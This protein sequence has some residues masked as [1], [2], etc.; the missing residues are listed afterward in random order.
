MSSLGDVIH[1]LPAVTELISAYPDAAIDWVVEEAFEDIPRLHPGLREVIPVAIR[2]WRKNWFTHISEVLAFKRRL[3]LENYDVIIDA[4]G[5]L[6]SALVASL[7]RGKRYGLDQTSSREPI[8]SRFYDHGIEVARDLH[9]VQRTRFLFAQA[10]Q[11]QVDGTANYGL[12]VAEHT[13]T[14]PPRL[15][16]L[17]GTT[18]DS[19]HWP[20]EYWLGLGQRCEKEGYQ[21]V[22]P[23]LTEQEQ[24]RAES[25]AS[26][27][28][29]ALLLPPGSLSS[30]ASAMS[31]CAGVVSVDSGLG[32][33]ATALNI[34][35][36]GIFGA[37]DPSRTGFLGPAQSVLISDAPGCIPCMK[38]TCQYKPGELW[39][40]I[41]PPCYEKIDP[42]TVWQKLHLRL[43]P[44]QG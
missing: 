17:H 43:N 34:P 5:L 15:M 28:N 3:R 32:H 37:T 24:A 19:K 7:A 40:N 29:N 2:R 31:Q 42:E 35:T 25:L 4:Q 13:Q 39:S 33:L 44:I 6:K 27:L 22:L 12:Q 9:A 18:W 21:V 20:D 36:V 14:R 8:A 26:T 23:Y 10:F 41:H 11:Y 1:T 16:F 38:R 30:M